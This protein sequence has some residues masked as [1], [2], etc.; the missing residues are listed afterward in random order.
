M[1]FPPRRQGG[2]LCTRGARVTGQVF[3]SHRH[4][5]SGRLLLR[6][7]PSY[8]PRGEKEG[9]ALGDRRATGGRSRRVDPPGGDGVHLSL[10]LRPETAP[11]RGPGW[12]DSGRRPAAVLASGVPAGATA[13]LAGR[14][15]SC[16]PARTLQ[17]GHNWLFGSVVPIITAGGKQWII[18]RIV[19]S[20]AVMRCNCE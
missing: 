16:S 9:G 11:R 2:L 3:S 17:V 15:G 12:L 10:P 5:S 18:D 6:Q 13:R 1:V 8:L 19:F 20:L 4:S 7:P 14:S